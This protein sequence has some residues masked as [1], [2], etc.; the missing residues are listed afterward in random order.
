MLLLTDALS[1]FVNIGDINAHLAEYE[2][3]ISNDDLLDPLATS[4]LV[5]MAEGYSLIFDSLMLNFHA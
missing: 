4:M 3:Q 5:L 1:G 2:K